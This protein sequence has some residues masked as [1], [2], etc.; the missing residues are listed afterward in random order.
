LRLKEAGHGARHAVVKEL[1]TDE[2]KLYCLSFAES[3]VDSK[4]DRVIFTDESIFSSASDGLVLV[5]RP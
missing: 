2:Y 5:Y 4:W 1:H 3:S